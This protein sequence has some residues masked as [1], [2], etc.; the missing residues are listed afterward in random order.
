[1]AYN[2]HILKIYYTRSRKAYPRFI[3]KTYILLQ[4]PKTL[5]S[6]ECANTCATKNTRLATYCCPT[7]FTRYVFLSYRD[8]LFSWSGFSSLNFFSSSIIII[9]KAQSHTH[10]FHT[11]VRAVFK[12]N[13]YISMCLCI[14]AKLQQLFRLSRDTTT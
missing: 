13:T 9:M 3:Y 6:H 11:W 12:A 10:Q 5:K 1:M 7:Q 2:F 14:I 4:L 8:F